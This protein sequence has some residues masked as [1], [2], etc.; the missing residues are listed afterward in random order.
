MEARY[1][2]E[3]NPDPKGSGGKKLLHPRLIPYKTYSIRDLMR[4]GKDRSTFSEADISGALKLITDLVAENLQGGNNVEIEGLGFFS[5]SL[6]SRPGMDKKELR[7]ESVHF[8]NVNFRCC[9]ALK[10]RL[11]TMPLSRI[12]EEK[13]RTFSDEEKDRRLQ[14]YM[15]RHPYITVL[16]YRS[17]NGCSDYTA[18]KELAGFVEEGTLEA[19]GTR[20]MSIYTRP[21]RKDEPETGPLV[22][23]SNIDPE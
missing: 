14:W 5:V 21:V 17:L 19:G 4:Y 16:K 6:K 10:D 3:E 7:S 15:D 9:Q 22:I 20:H 18:R 11:K 13:C 1:K 8:K 23:E 12:R 2:M